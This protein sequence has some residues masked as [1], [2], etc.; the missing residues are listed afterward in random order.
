MAML[1]IIL[2]LIIGIMQYRAKWIALKEI[3]YNY[4]L[5]KKYI[6]IDEPVE[7]KSTVTNES[8]RLVTSIRMVEIMPNSAR[9]FT[10]KVY[11]K[12]DS[13]GTDFVRY[14][15]S[16]SLTAR[17][18][19]TRKIKL[20]F[21]HRGRYVFRGAELS[22][23]GDFLG[24][25]EKHHFNELREVVV[26]PKAM[27]SPQFQEIMSD[28]LGDISVHR[29]IVEDPI[30]TI[31]IREYTGRE[32]LKQM[33]WIHTARMNQM[34]VKQFDYTT[35]MVV[36]VFLDVSVVRRKTLR[37][38]QFENCYSLARGVCQHLQR[39]KISFEFVTNTIEYGGNERDT[40]TLGNLQLNLILEKLGRAGYGTRRSYE[41]V[42]E[43]LS[44]EQE[45]D[46]AMLII[47]PRRDH[48][49][50][51]LAESFK[52]RTGGT[53]FFIYGED[54]GETSEWEGSE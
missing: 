21:H 22:S 1:I 32:P 45:K 16:L 6:E 17:S 30:L 13:R 41:S 49:K 23:G 36:T 15:S 53:V 8:H 52:A 11:T 18:I 31:G 5:S 39:H 40:E 35:E 48:D 38:A 54:F 20:T 34:M 28:F 47:T 29:F 46:R 26:L 43:S 14:N 25:L 27:E 19:F 50:Q 10:M 37:K 12:E 24:N 42:I 2:M 3:K 44:V 4:T 33:S 51:K 7:L 9:P